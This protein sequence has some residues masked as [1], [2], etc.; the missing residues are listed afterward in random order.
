MGNGNKIHLYAD[1]V[2]LYPSYSDYE[3]LQKSIDCVSCENSLT[4]NQS[5][6]KFML[7]SRKRNPVVCL[8]PLLLDGVIL[9]S[10]Q[11]F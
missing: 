6:C 3:D 10:V 8:R 1:D 5:K 11:S 4:L 2:L 7:I 9:E